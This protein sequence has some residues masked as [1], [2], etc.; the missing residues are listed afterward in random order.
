MPPVGEVMEDKLQY[1]KQGQYIEQ[2]ESPVRISEPLDSR[3]SQ[4]SV[5][6]SAYARKVPAL[7]TIKVLSMYERIGGAET[8]DRLV[9]SFYCRMD[10]LAEASVIRALHGPDLGPT[11]ATLK[12]YLGEWLG[13][14]AHYSA[15]KGHPRLRQR[16]LHV[17]IGEAES[18]AWLFCMKG[19]M[20]ET[21]AD[22]DAG[23]EIYVV[24]EKL[25]NWMRNTEGNP[26]DTGGKQS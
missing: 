21:I 19:A 24:I 15:A 23:K 14:P 3:Q 22:A 2:A 5:P 18:D 13:G 12:L 11:K 1:S 20:E 6:Q 7:T 26:H 4:R 8:V 16:H 17:Q 10:S 25:A 9:E